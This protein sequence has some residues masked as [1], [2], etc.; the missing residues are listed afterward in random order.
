MNIN[1]IYAVNVGETYQ[2]RIELESRFVLQPTEGQLVIKTG[3]WTKQDID[4]TP[5][6]IDTALE[7]CAEQ[8]NVPADKVVSPWENV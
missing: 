3:H 1:K 6:W 8:M 2:V 4:Y 5:E 7:R